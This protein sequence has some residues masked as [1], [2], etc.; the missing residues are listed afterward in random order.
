M[1]E[2]LRLDLLSAVRALS[3]APVTAASAMLTLSV[4]V[5]LN[6]AMFGLIDR[7]L[8]SPPAHVVDADRVFT[9]AFE[10]PQTQ[11]AQGARGR[12][13]TTS[14][15]AF[16]AIRD[17]VP[18]AANAAAFQ[19]TPTDAIVNGEPI[20]VDAMMVSG[21]YF[22]MLGVRPLL[23]RGIEPGDDAPPS[24]S[25]VAVL[26]YAFWRGTFGGDPGVIGR[27]IVVRGLE[28]TVA[29]IAPA[30]FSGHSAARVDVWLP[31]HSA[32]RDTPGWDRQQ[33]RNIAGI[34]VRLAPDSTAAAAAGQA[35]AALDR[36]V[37]L[38]PIAGADVA[39]AEQRIAYWLTGVSVLVLIIGLANTATLLLVRGA[40]RRRDLAIRTALGASRSRLITQVVIESAL[41]ATAAVVIALALASWF[42]EAVRTLLLSSVAESAGLSLRMIG[43]AVLAGLLALAVAAAALI[44]QVP[45]PLQGNDIAGATRG[46]PRARAYTA[47][48]LVQTTLSVV[49]LAGAGMFGRSLYNLV[50]QDFGMRMHDVLLVEFDRGPGGARERNQLF[51]S[52]VERLR[53]LPGVELATQI[54]MIPFTG[55]HVI[56]ISVP[57]FQ[58]PPNVNGQLPYLLA[59][60]PELLEIL[61]VTIVEGRRFTES[62]ER[63]APV[64]IVN[65]AMARTI[66]A[67][68]SALG[69]C[70]RI[71]FE[72]S[73]D[74]FTS[75]G[76]PP[77][78][79]T[80]PCRE[81]VG[82][83]RD[84]R[85]RSVV[86]TGHEDRLMQYY[87]PFTQVPTGPGGGPG[88]QGLLLRAAAGP[89]ALAAPIRRIVIGDRTDLPFLQVRR[90]S[91]VVD[92]QVR[93]WRQGTAL[94]SLFGALALGVAAI[95]LYAAFAHSVAERRREMAI[96][97]AIGAHTRGV[98]AMILR[99]AATV[100]AAGVVLGCAVAAIGGR[101][102]QSMLFGTAPTD[103]LVL[104][105]AAIVM[106]V[107]AGIATFVPARTAS[108]TDP[109]S[110]LRA[111]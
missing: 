106:L 49:L 90:Y 67:G 62:D 78:P 52:A 92:R 84:V 28:F 76:P 64:V 29:G 25:P 93:P 86:P 99:E 50:A 42:D 40:G 46:R 19:R 85:Q 11:G 69:K 56:P 21:A 45:G 48:L 104:G 79:T 82:V 71:G 89:D 80:V 102:L 32:M 65:E 83:A 94:L 57:G 22:T 24:G 58:G 100:A 2:R 96:R 6:L 1:T 38:S 26:S 36:R 55:F 47:L 31:F 75:G 33:F 8:L 43:A 34:A 105:L 107:V 68:Q 15:V 88:V 9:L 101:W 51:S 74:P 53:A 10:V 97:L 110:L 108:R 81:V 17:Q 111:E 61:D 18:A 13:T 27:H 16:E 98:L 87:L 14:Y 7:A 63:G 77:A 37:S 109:S 35:S 39:Q 91:E 5:G 3:R 41:L 12:M 23:G 103:P 66:W 95:G 60:T 54:Q 20:A 73:F 30:G 70:I 59:A 44:A 72:P 4:A